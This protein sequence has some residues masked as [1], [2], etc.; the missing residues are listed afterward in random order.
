MEKLIRLAA[1]GAAF[2][3]SCNTG[4]DREF[5]L[6]GSRTEQASTVDSTKILLYACNEKNDQASIQKFCADQ[7]KNFTGDKYTRFLY[8]SMTRIMQFIRS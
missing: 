2:F 5:E 7:K 1:F 3:A 6:V 4:T 8:S